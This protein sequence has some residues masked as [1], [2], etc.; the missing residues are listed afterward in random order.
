MPKITATL[1]TRSAIRKISLSAVMGLASG[2][3]A[4]WLMGTLM[5]SYDQQL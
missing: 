1:E 4:S 3:T 2:E 5:V